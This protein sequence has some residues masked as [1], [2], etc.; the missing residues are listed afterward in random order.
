MANSIDSSEVIISS[1]IEVLDDMLA[2]LGNFSINVANEY[3][4]RGT[5][6]KV[7]L[8]DSKDGARVFSATGGNAGYEATSESDVSTKDITVNEIIKPFRLSDN[9]LYKSPVNLSNYIA[10]NANA[11]GLFIMNQVKSAIEGGTADATKGAGVMDL[12][13]VKALVKKLDASGIPVNDRHLVLSH[14]AHHKL[15]PDNQDV[16]GTN[17]SVMQSGRV[18]QLYGLQVHPTSILETGTGSKKCT[19]FASGKNGI[20]IVNRIPETQGQETLQKYETFTIP[21][22]GMNVAYREHFNTATGTLHG[23]FSTLFGAT[24]GDPNAIAWVQGGA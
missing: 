23:C 5:T 15:L 19:A 9:E 13:T 1:A 6:I 16:Y 14:V 7:P 3:A 2:P 24:I 4:G 17:A 8:V 11:F 20:A 21:T 10:S 18:G 22:L 12:A